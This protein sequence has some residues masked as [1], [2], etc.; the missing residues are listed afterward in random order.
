MIGGT[1]AGW[2][3]SPKGLNYSVGTTN[4]I[5]YRSAMLRQHSDAKS[6]LSQLLPILACL[7]ISSAWL[8]HALE[9]AY[10]LIKK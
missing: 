6:H 2:I 1:F 9:V 3:K 7:Q 8:P 10:L 5:F 4:H